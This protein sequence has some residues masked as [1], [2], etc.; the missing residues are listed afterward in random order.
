MAKL[1]AL[2]TGGAGFLG[3]YL[4]DLL[5]NQGY[6][7]L[8]L[9][10]L[11]TGKESNI[12]RSLS[13]HDF[14]FINRDTCDLVK[15]RGKIDI[16]F[17]FASPASPI[18]YLNLPIETMKAGSFGTYNMLELARTNKC[19]FLIASTSEVYG[20][21]L[22]N[23][24]EESYWGNVDPIGPRSVYDESKRFSEALTM[25]YH[26]YYGLDIKLIRIFNTYGPRMRSDDGRV[27][28][29]LIMQALKNEPLTIFGDG[30]QTRSF[31][32]VSDLMDCIWRMARSGEHGPVNVGNPQEITIMEVAGKIKKITGCSSEIIHKPLPQDDPKLRRPDITKAKTLLGCSPSIDLD[33]GL[34]Q[35]ID[36]FK[37]N[38]I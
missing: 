19:K 5:L 34:S 21:P 7:V 14:K 23:P 15:L 4:C 18:D 36:W 30:L 13:N 37:Q 33:T 2:V 22:E 29:T 31:C 25:A 3:S 20:D 12:K 26:R 1:T 10:N 6:K 32:Y 35:T 28:P 17:H 9:D 11:I 8:C 24:Q 38:Y 16:I 27:L